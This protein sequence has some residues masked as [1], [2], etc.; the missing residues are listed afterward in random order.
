MIRFRRGMGR[1]AWRCWRNR[2][3]WWN[4]RKSLIFLL[5]KVIQ[6]H[7]SLIITEFFIELGKDEEKDNDEE[8]DGFFVPHGYLSSDEEQNDNGK[9]FYYIL[10]F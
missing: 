1:R 2:P 6:G 5:F 4:V 9:F 8:N 7:S 10:F 3:K